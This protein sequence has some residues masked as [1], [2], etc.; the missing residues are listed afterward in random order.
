MN[1]TKEEFLE[2][3]R[4]AM[5]DECRDVFVIKPPHKVEEKKTLSDKITYA[6]MLQSGNDLILMGNPSEENKKKYIEEGCIPVADVKEVIKEF[7]GKIENS[8]RTPIS[9]TT[10]SMAKEIFGERLVD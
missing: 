5:Y 9:P 8:Y 2:M 10:E 4:G 1:Y 6:F 7:I 3:L